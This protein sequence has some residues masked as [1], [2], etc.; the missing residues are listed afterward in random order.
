[1]KDCDTQ[2]GS[3]EV[4]LG[5]SS[6]TRWKQAADGAELVYFGDPMC[7][8]CWGTAPQL[9]SLREWG[10]HNN[11]PFRVVMGGLRAGG[12]EPWTDAFRN[13]LRHHWRD[14]A[15]RTGQTFN[16]D[17]LERE[18]FN[19]DTEPACRAVVTARSLGVPDEL[20]FMYRVQN[21]F[22]VLN[23]DPK[24]PEFY[25]AICEDMNLDTETF[26]QRFDSDEMK[27]RT[28]DDFR[29]CRSSGVSSFPTLALSL[30]A[31]LLKIAS[32]YATFGDMRRSVEQHVT[33]R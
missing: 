18:F 7:S 5:E 31:G 10:G 12:G 28:L 1:M 33:A 30:P 29:R 32:G 26:L 14:V 3:C 6:G 2:S 15:A 22:Y 27:Q 9:R 21:R 13:F 11:L 25:P 20:E 19:Y 16:E 24:E 23:E 17:L 8:W 4:P